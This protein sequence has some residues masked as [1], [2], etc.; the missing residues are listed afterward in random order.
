MLTSL[1]KFNQPLDELTCGARCLSVILDISFEK[2]LKKYSYLNDRLHPSEITKVLNSYNIKYNISFPTEEGN[3]LISYPVSSNFDIHNILYINGILYDSMESKEL[4]LNIQ[5]LKN[6]L[7]SK[8][9]GF[10]NVFYNSFITLEI[11]LK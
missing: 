3:Y 1:F 8:M 2:L 9:N 7:L 5:E 6:R 4:K 10:C 11:N